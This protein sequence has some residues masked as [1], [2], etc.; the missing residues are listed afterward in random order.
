MY[1]IM[2]T[3][4]TQL[5]FIIKYFKTCVIVLPRIHCS[6]QYCLLVNLIQVLSLFFL[7]R[8][9][10]NHIM[11]IVGWW[12]SNTIT[13]S[14]QILY[15]VHIMGLI[16]Y[17]IYPVFSSRPLS[18][19]SPSLLPP[20]PLPCPLPLPP[21]P[22]HPLSLSPH[23]T[24]ISQQPRPLDS[25]PSSRRGTESAVSQCNS[26]LSVRCC[27]TICL[28]QNFFVGLKVIKMLGDEHF[29]HA[30]KYCF[31]LTLSVFEIRLFPLF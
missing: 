23:I 30:I 24:T 19:T 16:C 26:S 7:E 6:H 13:E 12:S 14:I 4:N 8:S 1:C 31:H 21:Y 27:K 20:Y 29:P 18:P 10:C 25:T 2:G 15:Y 22:L 9:S 3:F 28:F 5:V 11:I 17:V